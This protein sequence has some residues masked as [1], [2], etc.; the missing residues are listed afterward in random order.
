MFIGLIGLMP[1]TQKKKWFFFNF[2][3]Q[4]KKNS[5]D[6]VCETC[7]GEQSTDAL[8]TLQV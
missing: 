2:F 8:S 7:E 5:A 3:A 6:L 4:G 1:P